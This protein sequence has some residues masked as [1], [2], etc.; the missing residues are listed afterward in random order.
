MANFTLD[1]D[2]MFLEFPKLK[3][4]LLAINITSDE[5]INKVVSLCNDNMYDYI[6]VRKAFERAS[7]IY[8]QE[9]GKQYDYDKFYEK[10][11][12]YF[13]A[14]LVC[15]YIYDAVQ[16]IDE[17]PYINQY[18]RLLSDKMQQ[19]TYANGDLFN[20]L[21]ASSI[22][23]RLLAMIPVNPKNVGGLL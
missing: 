9:S 21:Q 16:N 5:A 19:G 15:L 7:R 17:S 10:L 1:K 18:A 23:Q 6:G 13:T 11:E 20:I 22:G 3:S 14:H 8:S 4:G 2:L 12:R